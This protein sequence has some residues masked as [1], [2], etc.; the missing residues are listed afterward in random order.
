MF[1]KCIFFALI[2][3]VFYFSKKSEEFYGGIVQ[4]ECMGN[5]ISF[6]SYWLDYSDLQL[7]LK[8]IILYRIGFP[9]VLI[10]FADALYIQLRQG[11]KKRKRKKNKKGKA[12]KGDGD[13]EN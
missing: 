10:L 11:V 3:M 4:K 13:E 8:G 6:N 2:A 1:L 5:D 7:E 12:T 9:V